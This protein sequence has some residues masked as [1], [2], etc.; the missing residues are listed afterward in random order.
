M[1]VQNLNIRI[2]G[3]NTN[4]NELS[5]AELG[6]LLVA[7]NIEIFKPGI[8]EP[9]RGFEQYVY[10]PNTDSRVENF[11]FYQSAIIAKYG[12]NLLYST[13]G[14]FTSYTISTGN[15]SGGVSEPTGYKKRFMQA[16]QNLYM[17]GSSGVAKLD[18]YDATNTDRLA[19]GRKAQDMEGS[20]TGASGFM[21]EGFRV[22]Y[23]HIWCK[24][25]ANDNLVIGAPSPRVI[26]T[27]ASGSGSTK[28]ASI[29]MTIPSG[30]TTSWFYQLYRSAQFASSAEPNDELQLVKEGFPTSGQIT[31]GYMTVTDSTTDALRGATLYTSPSQEG[32]AFAN[33]RLPIAVD[34]AVFDNC[35]FYANTTSPSRFNLSITDIGASAGLQDGDTIT[36][37]GE[38]LT[39][40]T[41]GEV[42]SSGYF[43]LQTSGTMAVKIEETARSLVRVINRFADTSEHVAAYYVSGP[44]DAPGKILIERST[45][46]GGVYTIIASRATCWTPTNIPTSGSTVT[47][48]ADT[49]VNAIYWSKPNQPEHVPLVNYAF[50]GSGDKAIKRIIALREALIIMKEDGVFRVTGYY[51][52]FGVEL[53]DPT[54]KI[55]GA[56]TANS[57]DNEIY[58]LSEQG[59]AVISDDVRIISTPIQDQLKSLVDTNLTLIKSIGWGVG[60]QSDNKYCLYLPSASTDTYP[61]QSFVFNNQTKTWVRHTVPAY[62]GVVYNNRLYLADTGS[63]YI[64][65]DR[66]NYTY[67]DYADHAITT[68]ISAI[69]STTITVASGVDNISVGDV[70]YQSTSLFSVITGVTPSSGTFTVNSNPGFTVAACSILH[71]IVTDIK[72]GPITSDNAGVQKHYHT[73]Q[74]LF[75][76][77]FTGTAT[78]AFQSDIQNSEDIV[79]L[80]GTAIGAWGLFTWGD[81]PWGASPLRSNRRQWIPR[82]KQRASE[83]L[84]SFRHRYGYSAWQLQGVSVTGEGGSEN[85][86]R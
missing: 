37:N 15:Y 61:T 19:G 20:T 85:T 4:T 31:T 58:M 22:A 5:S 80:R 36:I 69:D 7:D 29:T 65:K 75:K 16:N 84:I 42:T 56:E 73:V 8:A 52:N 62:T 23:R 55:V 34:L 12:A 59:V 79:T 50:V 14:T 24:T 67:L 18:A 70:L 68:S 49:Y 43:F 6:S 76:E 46:Q 77:D 13:G 48:A 81:V 47:S 51:P 53:M 39:A 57:L 64:L 38:A 27:N 32:L 10:V 66:K 74:M 21:A 60:Y 2:A 35:M 83:L 44:N 40:K 86:T 30:L 3:L 54:T 41:S 28:N 72:W 33:E 26:V 25:D 78:L 45:L 71:S 82:G 63:N 17:T 9:R 1:A 11:A